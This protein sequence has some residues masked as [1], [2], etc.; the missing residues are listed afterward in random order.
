MF[1]LLTTDDG[2]RFS[3]HAAGPISG[4]QGS[5]VTFAN[6]QDAYRVAAPGGGNS[7]LFQS[8]D[9]G[10][11]WHEVSFGKS[12]TVYGLDTAGDRV[13]AIVASCSGP[14]HCNDYRL[15]RSVAG[16]TSWASA[17]IPGSSG[18][19]GAGV[20]LGAFGSNVWL[21]LG[22]GGPVRLLL[23]T[24]FGR[25]FTLE[26]NEISAIECGPISTSLTVVWLSCSTGMEGVWLRSG[27]AGHIF[28][29]LPVAGPSA[30]SIIDPVSDE[31]AFFD[32]PLRDVL[33][34]T[35]NGGRT[36]HRVSALPGGDW[37]FGNPL[38]GLDAGATGLWRTIDGGSTWVRVSS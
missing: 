8:D 23:S 20:G 12:T 5:G 31:V 15:A 21:T 7:S 2:L 17:T 38:D 22:N 16:S 26:S 30:G 34:R 9:A 33:Y 14:F 6:L 35:T 27:D 4:T 28:R 10:R 3:E 11:T 19:D 25:S 29:G 1:L 36:F 13:Y 24:D 18:L 32:S 37:S